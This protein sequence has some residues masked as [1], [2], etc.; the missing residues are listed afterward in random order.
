MAKISQSE[1]TKKNKIEVETTKTTKSEPSH[2]RSALADILRQVEPPQGEAQNTNVT[3]LHVVSQ[4]KDVTHE[5]KIVVEE[6]TISTP[7][8]VVEKKDEH[9]AELERLAAETEAAF[10][11]LEQQPQATA[12][13]PLAAKKIER[14]FKESTAQRS[15]FA[16]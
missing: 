5:E 10:S 2:L 7:P 11:S 16:S 8:P 14:L 4:T 15:P 3:K 1:S 9:R 12:D 13:D 6:K